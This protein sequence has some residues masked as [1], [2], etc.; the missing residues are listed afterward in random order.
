MPAITCQYGNCL[1]LVGDD[2]IVVTLK[3]A[4]FAGALSRLA[5]DRGLKLDAGA[6]VIPQ[7]WRVT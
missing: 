4:T 7:R 3:T 2:G 1:E 5:A 6:I